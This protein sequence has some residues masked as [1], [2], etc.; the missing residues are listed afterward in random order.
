MKLKRKQIESNSSFRFSS[1]LFLQ[2]EI[3]QE[4]S[5]NTELISLADQI[6]KD[7]ES[8]G[9]DTL[10]IIRKTNFDDFLH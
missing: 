7:A 10:D 4:A 6:L 8:R 1:F 2:I 5:R 9:V 3:M